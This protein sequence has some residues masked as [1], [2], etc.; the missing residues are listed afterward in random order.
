MNDIEENKPR[1]PVARRNKFS[2]F[3]KDELKM[4]GLRAIEDRGRKP[5]T[6]G[7]PHQA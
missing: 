1:R 7:T 6:R 3:S 4:R 5:L 2:T